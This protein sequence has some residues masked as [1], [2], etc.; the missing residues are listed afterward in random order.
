M[1][2][3]DKYG[4]NLVIITTRDVGV[5]VT[6][7]IE[8]GYLKGLDKEDGKELFCWHTFRQPYPRNGYEDLV[9]IF[10]NKCGGLPLS[11][12][13][14]GRHV[15]GK[16]PW[17]WREE[18]KKVSKT[19]PGDVRKRLK[20]SFDSLDC[21]EQ[22]IFMDV[23][24]FFIDKST[25]MATSIWE[26]SG[27]SSHDAL[28]TL[29]DKCLVE[30]VDI[31][32]WPSVDCGR[33]SGRH[34]F[35][36]RMYDHLRD[37]G[38]ELAKEFSHPR[39]V[40]HPQHLQSLLDYSYKLVPAF[41]NFSSKNYFNRSQ[42]VLNSDINPSI[43]SWIPLQNLQCLTIRGVR[44]QR[45]WQSAMQAPSHLKEL[46]IIGTYLEEFPDLKELQ[47][48]GTYLEEFPDLLGESDNME[49]VVLHATE[50]QMDIWSLLGSLRM[51]LPCLNVMHSNLTGELA[52]TDTAERTAFKSLVIYDFKL[53][54]EREMALNNEGWYRTAMNDVEYLEI[55]GHHFVK[56]I[57]ITRNCC[58]CQQSLKICEMKDLIEVDLAR[59]NT[60]NFLEITN[61]EKL[62]RL[63]LTSDPSKLIELKIMGC[64]NL[65]RVSGTAD[66]T[67][68]TQ[69]YINECP[70]LQ[71]EPLGAN[72]DGLL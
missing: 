47:I 64:T 11:L 2:I 59:I 13:V 29:K 68:L 1:D 16:D 44:Y 55:K 17:Y 18:L 54:G 61:C 21:E 6:A 42:F 43:P 23:A 58:Q 20:I 35:V 62:K 65:E 4:N 38:R 9:Q 14:L 60:L 22:Q 15:S 56:K 72:S 53:P 45:L 19:L 39:R 40:W 27:W 24:C 41:I 33:K 25:T 31:R 36:L 52:S 67:K 8:I 63:I 12:Q 71:S 48:I 51:K 34:R 46:Q 32:Y 28:E 30:E 37:L 57:L 69:L 66:L 26:G 10:V 7:G 70:K 5:L 3:L 50:F 49:A